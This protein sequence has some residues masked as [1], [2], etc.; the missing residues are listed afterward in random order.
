[1]KVF[2]NLGT[3][4]SILN[5]TN[6]A[7]EYYQKVLALNPNHMLAHFALG[8]VL[9]KSN[10]PE[11]AL[12]EYK[13]AIKLNPDHTP[14]YVNLGHTLFKLGQS[15]QA[16]KTYKTILLKQPNIPEVHKSLGLIYSQKK[17]NP[18]KAIHHFQ[19]YLRLSPNQHD[20]TQINFMIQS[21]K[22]EN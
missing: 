13:K 2:Y 3:I 21:L 14:S 4:Y 10:K 19:E 11:S 20:A 17:E 6:E 12:L 5:K 1:M 15:D 16:Q 7:V 22:I 9:L 8:N 18:D